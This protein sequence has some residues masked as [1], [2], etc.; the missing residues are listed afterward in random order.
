LRLAHEVELSWSLAGCGSGQLAGLRRGLRIVLG[1]AR[2]GQQR[3]GLAQVHQADP[4]R[5]P[6]GLPDLAG[7]GPDHTS[8]GGDRVQLVVESDDERA[9]QR[10]TPAVVLERQHALAAPTL[11]RVV[12]DRGALGI[13]ARGGDQHEGSGRTTASA[14]SRSPALNRIP[15]TPEV[16]RPIGRSAS[17]LA[18][19]RIDCPRRDQQ[20]VV[21]RRAQHGADQL[22]VVA[23]VDPDQAAGAVRVEV[24]QPRLLH[25]PVR[26]ASTRYGAAW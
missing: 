26:V 23:Q 9:H 2:D 20:Q 1:V 17:S 22:V 10:A 18:L 12:L 15:S 16:A 8:G 4:L 21:A 13:P 25:Q 14:S 11:H 7:R 6:T 24:R 3:G 19:N 5:L